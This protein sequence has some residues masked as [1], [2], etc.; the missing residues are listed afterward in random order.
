LATGCDDA[1]NEGIEQITFADQDPPVITVP[2]DIFV[3][4]TSTGG[5]IVDYTVTVFDAADANP[6]LECLPESGSV[7]PVGTTPVTCNA[8]DASGNQADS[9]G[10]NVVVQDT[11]VPSISLVGANPQVIEAGAPYEE[12]GATATDAVD[13]DATLTASIVIDASAVDTSTVGS[14]AVTYNVS[15]SQGNAAEEVTRSVDV[16]D[17]TAPEITL[18][19]STPVTVEVGTAYTDAGAK[20]TDVG[21]DDATL[22]SAIITVNPVDANTVGTYTVTYNVTDSQGNAAAEV[23]RTVDVVDKTAPVIT[24]LGSTPVTVEVGGT[25]TD[26]GATALDTGDGDLTASIARLAVTP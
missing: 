24:L 8:T 22:T 23:T 12:L 11:T 25:Y 4:A 13:N 26:A 10:F 16:V 19:G 21:D 6:S 15:D 18:L 20:A 2:D 9:A 17:T 1:L 7:F 3:E 14:Y 5:T